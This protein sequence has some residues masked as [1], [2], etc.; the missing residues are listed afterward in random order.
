M[1]LFVL[2]FVFELEDNKFSTSCVHFMSKLERAATNLP[3][4]AGQSFENGHLENTFR[5]R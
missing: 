5:E 1:F 4:F 2:V 3:G